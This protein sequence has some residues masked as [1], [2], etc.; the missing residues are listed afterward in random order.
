MCFRCF[1]NIILSDESL[2]YLR[3]NC[4]FHSYKLEVYKW[5][6]NIKKIKIF[7]YYQNV[8]VFYFKYTKKK[9]LTVTYNFFK[10]EI[11]IFLLE[12]FEDKSSLL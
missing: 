8:L 9:L 3:T 6:K 4:E 1:L 5:K 2:N 10:I 7:I 12:L 11:S